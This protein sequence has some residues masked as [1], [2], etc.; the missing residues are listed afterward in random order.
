[1]PAFCEEFKTLLD[2]NEIEKLV[3]IVGDREC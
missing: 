2:T 1:M 3:V